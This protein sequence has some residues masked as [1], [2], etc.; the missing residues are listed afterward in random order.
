VVEDVGEPLCR[1]RRL[2][3]T[4]S[5]SPAESAG[6]ASCSGSMLSAWSVIGSGKC[7]S[8][9]YSRRIQREPGMLSAT[10]PTALTSQAS[11]LSISPAPGAAEP[12][13]RLLHG[14]VGLAHGARHP[15]GDGSQPG[16]VLLGSFCQPVALVHRS[17]GPVPGAECDVTSRCRR[18]LP[19]VSGNES[20]PI[21]ATYRARSAPGGS[22]DF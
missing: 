16:P 9:G 5:A 1:R 17:A 18:G 8:S 14:F 2:E 22:R 3:H 19:V 12:D 15:I 4:S 10:R 7:A 20:S 11:R 6:S 21:M 13:P